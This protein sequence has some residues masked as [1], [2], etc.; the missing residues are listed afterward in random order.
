M[1]QPTGTCCCRATTLHFHLGAQ[2]QPRAAPRLWNLLQSKVSHTG[3]VF[4]PCCHNRAASSIWPSASHLQELNKHFWIAVQITGSPC[5]L[6]SLLL[7]SII[8]IS[9]SP[10][11]LSLF[12]S[13]VLIPCPS[14][15]HLRYHLT[16]YFPP[17]LT[18]LC[19][20]FS[21]SLLPIS[22]T[23]C[24]GNPSPRY[25]IWCSLSPAENFPLLSLFHPISHSLPHAPTFYHQN[26][27][28]VAL[29][30]HCSPD[31]T[32]V[33][34]LTF[35]HPSIHKLF[36]TG[37]S[38]MQ[39]RQAWSGGCWGCLRDLGSNRASGNKTQHKFCKKN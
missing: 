14:F 34:R 26:T 12:S 18:C 38:T 10:S 28:S 22:P 30:H 9:P 27:V 1:P 19:P 15:C 33:L 17:S 16:H 29:H 36:P 35:T 24:P 2:Q 3:Q 21:F 13:A 11:K 5:H 32:P 37:L 31:Q 4:K 8:S 20:S 39:T 6:C 23:L 25:G 7:N